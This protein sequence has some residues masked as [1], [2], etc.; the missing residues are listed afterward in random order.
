M[1]SDQLGILLGLSTALTFT[2]LSLFSR[3]VQHREGPWRFIALASIAPLAICLPAWLLF[4]PD[5]SWELLRAVLIAAVPVSLG[6]FFMGLAVRYADVS[7]VGPIMGSKALLTTIMAA[8]FGFEPVRPEMWVAAGILVVALFLVAGN[9]QVLRRPWVIVDR[10]LVLAG[11]MCLF[12]GLNDLIAGQQMR[13]YDLRAWDFLSVS[14]L[15]RGSVSLVVLTAVC[16]ARGLRIL[17]QR[18][19]TFWGLAVTVVAHGL[20]FIG[21]IKLTDSA[22]L[23][24]VLSSLRG[25]ASVAAVVLLARW[26]LSRREVLSPGVVAAR[27]VGSVLVCGAVAL[28]LL[29]LDWLPGW[30]M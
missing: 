30:P 7:H 5:W 22:V 29:G 19:S 9:R 27:V 24:N 12:T 10:G 4:P 23:V 21:A 26:G 11:L 18:A 3:E 13:T 15:L 8:V 16:R 25:L 17:P 6:F 14:W 2:A 1:T 28:A 20:A